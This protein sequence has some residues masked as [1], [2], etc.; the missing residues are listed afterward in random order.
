MKKTSKKDIVW[1]TD[2]LNFK[3]GLLFIKALR[4]HKLLLVYN[5][6]AL[7]RPLEIF[8]SDRSEVDLN[9]SEGV[10]ELENMWDV[11]HLITPIVST[12][13]ASFFSNV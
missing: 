13:F 2:S 9:T 3:R 10:R 7:E 1:Q 11:I 6:K 8:F 5:I 4:L 12:T